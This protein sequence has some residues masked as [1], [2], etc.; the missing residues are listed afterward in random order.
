MAT[1][2]ERVIGVAAK[3]IAPCPDQL[4]EAE[5]SQGLELLGYFGLF[6]APRPEAVAAVGECRSA[7]IA[8]RMVTGDHKATAL[9]I[10]REVGI[11][12]GGGAVTGPE[13]AAL[14]DDAFARFAKATAV[15]ARTVPEDKLRLVKTLQAEGEVVAMT[16]DGVNDAP[17]LSR[18]H[19]GV[20][21]GLKGT[22]VAREAADIVLA[23][24]NFATVAA[25]VREGRAVFDNLRKTLLFILPTDAGEALAVIAA[26]VFGLALA[27]TPVQILWVNLATAITLS[28]A[29]AFE[30]AE[31]GTMRRSPRRLG[32]GLMDRLLLWR[33]I[34]VG[35]LMAGGA[36]ALFQN[37]LASGHGLAAARTAAVNALVFAQA[38]YLFTLRGLRESA[39][40]RHNA[41]ASKPML[42]AVGLTLPLQLAFT[43]LPF[44]NTTFGTAPI[45]A[46]AWGLVVAI[47]VGIF[48]A[49]EIE[50]AA[51]RAFRRRS[52]G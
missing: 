11:D 21:M 37:E 46:E 28:L 9:A 47:A 49:V 19:V 6:D 10:A 8:V 31:P 15:F 40:G 18:A 7:G 29:L 20:A 25:A 50:K 42:I 30:G 51:Q 14:D 3:V 34:F 16:G 36:L 23:D 33:V 13:L 44:F 22:D 52:P 35:I 43:Y 1:R 41:F 2:G 32:E 17:A 39:F 4:D 38:G 24:D 5:L 45:D 27:V 48:A 26:M 12:T